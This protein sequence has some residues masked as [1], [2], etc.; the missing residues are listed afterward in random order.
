MFTNAEPSVLASRGRNTVHDELVELGRCLVAVENH[1]A[2]GRQPV[3]DPRLVDERRL[4]YDDDVG[5]GDR[6]VAADLA[7]RFTRVNACIGAPRRRPVL[8]QRLHALTGRSGQREQLGRSWRPGRRGRASAPRSCLFM[9]RLLRSPVTASFA[10]APP[11]TTLAPPFVASPAVN[12]F[13]FPRA[14]ARRR[15]ALEQGSRNSS[16]GRC[17]IAFTTVSPGIRKSCREPARAAGARFV[18][19][20][21]PHSAQRIHRPA[22]RRRTRRTRRGT[23]NPLPRARQ[24]D[25][26]RE[27]LHLVPRSAGTRGGRLPRR[28][29]MPRPRRRPPDSAA[30][31]GDPVADGRRL[32]GLDRSDERE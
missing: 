10:P 30:Y 24:L 16:R 11:S 26:V 25:L 14:A 18:R 6:V 21:E 3:R 2:V 15:R 29:A 22:P 1:V 27:G 13:G 9:Q 8:R 5:T 20:A 4:E 12:I 32:A 19:R 23:R 7:L 17:P 31:D 28:A